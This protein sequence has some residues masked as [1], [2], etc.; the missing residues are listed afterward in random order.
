MGFVDNTETDEILKTPDGSEIVFEEPEEAET[1]A[2]DGEEPEGS[3]DDTEKQEIAPDDAEETEDE[4]ESDGEEK[5]ARADSGSIVVTVA[6]AIIGMVVGGIPAAVA[7]GLLEKIPAL[8]FLCVP[9]CICLAI[10][11]FGG[12]RGVTALIVTVIFAALGMCITALMCRAAIYVHQTH[13]SFL[14]VPLVAATRMREGALF[15][16]RHSISATLFPVIFTVIGTAASWFTLYK[17]GKE[18]TE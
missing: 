16:D 14:T 1:P 4:A 8:L 3:P 6:A 2:A 12:R 18:K 11:L 17:T 13:E 5:T 7:A 9:I 10:A 15:G